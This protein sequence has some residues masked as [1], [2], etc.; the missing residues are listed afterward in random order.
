MIRLKEITV[1]TAVNAARQRGRAQSHIDSHLMILKEFD[2]L[3]IYILS[4]SYER[5]VVDRFV[6]KKLA[7]PTCPVTSEAGHYGHPDTFPNKMT[8]GLKK[9]HSTT[10]Y[11]Q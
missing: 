7:K 1:N 5:T 3:F 4:F 10:P 6:H 11:N 2:C 8:R 9:E